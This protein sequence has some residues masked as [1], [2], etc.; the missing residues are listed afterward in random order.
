MPNFFDRQRA[1]AKKTRRHR[2]QRDQRDLTIESLEQRILLAVVSWDGGGDGTTW[3]DP[4]N[5]SGDALPGVNDDAVLDV[6]TNPNITLSSI[7]TVNSVT[8]NEL[9]TLSSATLTVNAN[10]Q[11]AGKQ[12]SSGVRS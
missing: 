12:F 11:F 2:V 8:S 10:S 6:A 5:W 4:L 3:E 9:L 1:H 7:Q